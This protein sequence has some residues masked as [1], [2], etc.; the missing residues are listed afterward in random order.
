MTLREQ[1]EKTGNWFFRW[2]S[3]LPFI[4][5]PVLLLALRQSEFLERIVGDFG[6][7][8]FEGLALAIAFTGLAV[9]CIVVGCAPRGTSG[10]NT[11]GQQAASLNTTGMYSIVRH[12]LYLG[13][14]LIFLGMALFTEVYWFILVSVLAFWLYYER[15]MFAEEKFLQETFGD[16]FLDWAG[17]TPA[18]VP[19]FRNWQRPALPFSFRNVLKREYSGFFVIV[20]SFT[21][22][23]LAG[24]MFVVEVPKE[25]AFEDLF[26]PIFFFVGLVIYM[27]LRTLKRKTTLLDVDGR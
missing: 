12:P 21:F 24:E 19:K 11:K 23:E 14:F 6:E 25:N 9:R 26:W 1:F 18:F 27:S 17:K 16:E 22:I 8:L 13:N 2:R 20:A 3:Y 10:R 5:F 7:D 4:L 15:I